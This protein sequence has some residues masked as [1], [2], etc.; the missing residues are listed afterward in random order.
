MN[1]IP[2]FPRPSS[3]YVLGAN[4]MKIYEAQ[5][6]MMLRDY[7]AAKALQASIISGRIKEMNELCNCAYKF[8]DAMLKARQEKEGDA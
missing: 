3:E 5:N 7:F 6:G 1:D 2:A 8:A 4:E